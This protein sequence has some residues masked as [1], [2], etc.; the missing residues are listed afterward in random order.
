M[1]FL[2]TKILNIILILLTGLGIY[3]LTPIIGQYNAAFVAVL[4]IMM[5]FIIV[6]T[7]L[8]ASKKRKRGAKFEIRDIIITIIAVIS[9][10]IAGLV[11]WLEPN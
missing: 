4:V 11:A 5:S 6:P 9:V 2:S 1:D 8:E 10:V 7:F 3:F